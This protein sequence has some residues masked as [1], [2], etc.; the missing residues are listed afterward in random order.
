LRE[1]FIYYRVKPAQLAQARAAV[2]AMQ[3]QLQ[4]AHPQL[5]ARLLQRDDAQGGLHTWMETYRTEPHR[6]AAGIGVEL[7]AAIESAAIAVAPFIA[8]PRHTEVFVACA[9]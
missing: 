1:L 3:A 7:Q 4:A 2:A 6:D 9:S 8:G 5:V